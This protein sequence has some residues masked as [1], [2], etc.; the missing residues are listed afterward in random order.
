MSSVIVRHLY[1][2]VTLYVIRISLGFHSHLTHFS[3]VSHFY[4]PWKRQKTK[5]FLTLFSDVFRRYR[6]V[7]LAWNG[8][9][10][11]HFC[12]TR[13]SFVCH[14][15]VILCTR[16]SLVCAFRVKYDLKVF[17]SL[18]KSL[19]PVSVVPDFWKEFELL[20]QLS[21]F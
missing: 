7:T 14:S 10:V 20:L 6:N 16:I 3:P 18:W 12:F 19:K 15:Y 2:L 4:T 13:I 5:G 11:C 17:M 21:Q 9:I 8:L 1:L